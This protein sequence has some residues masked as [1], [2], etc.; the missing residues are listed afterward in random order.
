MKKVLISIFTLLVFLN[1]YSI[2]ARAQ[3][4][5]IELP[6]A[7]T[8]AGLSGEV[9]S[10]DFSSDDQFIITG[11]SRGKISTWNSNTGVLVESWEDNKYSFRVLKVLYSPDDKKIASINSDGKIKLWDIESR[12]VLTMSSENILRGNDIVFNNEGTILYSTNNGSNY[13][14]IFWDV[15]TGKKLNE[16]A[17]PAKP[18]SVAYSPKY[19][20]LAV[21]L[22]DGSVNIRD[23]KT[24]AYIKAVP[25]LITGSIASQK[26]VNKLAYS[27]DN[28]SLVCSNKEQGQP[29]L[30]Q[31][32]NDYKNTA[33]DDSQYKLMHGKQYWMDFSFSSN[34]KYVA[35]ANMNFEY[36][37]ETLIIF[38]TNTKKIISA[39]SAPNK[40]PS[41]VMF[42]HNNKRIIAGDVIFDASVLPENHLTEGEVKKESSEAAPTNNVISAK[43]EDVKDKAVSGGSSNNA[44]R[45]KSIFINLYSSID[46]WNQKLLQFYG[47]LWKKVARM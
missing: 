36:N 8:L 40:F 37:G 27:P 15:A 22:E 25:N 31:V 30:L 14:V 38:D 34:N 9:V 26:E 28:E 42:S 2:E 33:L 44:Q 7:A 12:K 21:G 29:Y 6:K 18:L 23:A 20:H 4:G 47:N 39:I 5:L 10:V 13:S 43:V 19:N 46:Q 24:G 35:V 16:I 45:S 41:V 17:F 32:N 3:D 1:L 11:D